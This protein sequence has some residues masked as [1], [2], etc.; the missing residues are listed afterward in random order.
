MNFTIGSAEPEDKL[1][2]SW[3]QLDGVRIYAVCTRIPDTRFELFHTPQ[4]GPVEQYTIQC[5]NEYAKDAWVRDITKALADAGKQ[6][7]NGFPP[8]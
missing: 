2:A 4:T 6:E 7:A 3:F 8:D 1:T 5:K